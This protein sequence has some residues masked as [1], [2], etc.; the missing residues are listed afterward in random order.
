[1]TNVANIFLKMLIEELGR[2]STN[3]LSKSFTGSEIM[4]T[5]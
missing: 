2:I 5:S 1:M 4:P 3:E